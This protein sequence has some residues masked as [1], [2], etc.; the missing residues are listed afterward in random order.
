MRKTVPSSFISCHIKPK[1][2]CLVFNSPPTQ[3]CGDN[4]ANPTFVFSPCFLNRVRH[5]PRG[6]RSYVKLNKH[7]WA[8][9]YA[10]PPFTGQVLRYPQCTDEPTHLMRERS[11]VG[12]EFHL[13][14]VC[15]I[16]FCEPHMCL[17]EMS[18]QSDHLIFSRAHQ[19]IVN[20]LSENTG[21]TTCSQLWLR[22][23]VEMPS[24]T[25]KG[26]QPLSKKNMFNC[27]FSRN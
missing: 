18:S 13:C 3:I 10:K 25:A 9:R 1:P 26:Q 6:E 14:R 5:I 17:A 19:S 20:I 27:I 2:L 7:Q 21:E 15:Y 11:V 24:A 12:T 22:R 16:S 8:I 4:L 23:W